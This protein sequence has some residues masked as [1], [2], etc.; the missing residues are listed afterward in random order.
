MEEDYDANVLEAGDADDQENLAIIAEGAEGAEGTEGTVAQPDPFD[1]LYKFHPETVLDYA[2]KVMPA[3]PLRVVTGERT[4][5]GPIDSRHMS[6][7]FMTVFERTK[8][9]GTRANQLAQGARPFVV[10]PE[11]ITSPLEIAKMEL[12]QRRLPFIVK[13]PMPDGS[14]EYWRLSDLMIL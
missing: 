7:P 11:H 12:E 10:V 9:L 8:I 5:D 14:F 3:V 13:R 6:Q 4:G 2:E 1:I